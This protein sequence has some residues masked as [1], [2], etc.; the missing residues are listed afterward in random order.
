MDCLICFFV[1]LFLSYG[2]WMRV[3]ENMKKYAFEELF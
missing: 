2:Y 1:Q 3:T